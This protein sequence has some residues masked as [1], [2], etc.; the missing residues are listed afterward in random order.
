MDRSAI[1]RKSKRKGAVGERELA[2]VL[3]ENGHDCKRGCQTSG[4][5]I[6]DVI[7]L[8]GIHIE[9]KRAEK[10]SMKDWLEQAD[11]DAKGDEIPAVFHRRNREGWQVTMRLN[12]WLKLY[13]GW[14][15]D[16]R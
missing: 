11:R 6:A 4:K 9:C 8:D 14:L 16:K 1:G 2:A 13:E 7:G 12:Q 15:N 10:Q 3:T 5:T